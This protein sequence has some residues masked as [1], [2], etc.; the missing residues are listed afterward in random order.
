M[1][2]VG[3]SDDRQDRQDG[4]NINSAHDN[5]KLLCKSRPPLSWL[6]RLNYCRTTAPSTPL[7]LLWVS[8]HCQRG[9]ARTAADDLTRTHESVPDN[10]T[11]QDSRPPAVVSPGQLSSAQPSPSSAQP[12]SGPACVFVLALDWA[13]RHEPL[14]HTAAAWGFTAVVQPERRVSVGPGP[15]RR[16]PR[17]GGPLRL[18]H[19][20]WEWG[21][22]REWPWARPWKRERECK[23]Q[24]Q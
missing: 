1:S 6:H 13:A 24:W 22:A 20:Q 2:I 9:S 16:R 18:G 21:R 5:D 23:W 3:E 11:N 12:R 8:C 10:L 19:H 7:P 17:L 14:Q 15:H 4:H